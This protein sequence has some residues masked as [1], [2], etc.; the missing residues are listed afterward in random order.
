L[1]RLPGELRNKIYN[2]ALEG[3]HIHPREYS[4]GS[5]LATQDDVYVRP[6]AIKTFLGWTHT[7]RQIHADVGVLPFRHIIVR[8]TKE[9]RYYTE[10]MARLTDAQ[11]AA[12]LTV[13]VSQAE[14]ASAVSYY[15]IMRSMEQRHAGDG[16]KQVLVDKGLLRV[17]RWF[18][19]QWQSSPNLTRV[20]VRDAPG[21]LDKD[22]ATSTLRYC[23]DNREI[24]IEF[25]RSQS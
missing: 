25:V 23:A 16:A 12:I 17:K 20:L 11:R 5:H 22:C 13:E 14:V 15:Q 3:I 24:E 1:L 9:Q 7:C 4:T 10:F 2:Y 21:S 8:A 6:R 19:W 18:D